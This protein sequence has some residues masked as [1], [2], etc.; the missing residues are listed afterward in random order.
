MGLFDAINTATNVIN[1]KT[2]Q[3]KNI[4][5]GY[6]ISTA[7][8]ASFYSNTISSNLA[9]YEGRLLVAG[10]LALSLP[11]D[12]TVGV[13]V[14]GGLGI[15]AG[16]TALQY[17]LNNI[18]LSQSFAE[19]DVLNTIQNLSAAEGTLLL[20]YTKDALGNIK[21][22]LYSQTDNLQD[23]LSDCGKL[24]LLMKKLNELGVPLPINSMDNITLGNSLLD[25]LNNYDNNFYYELLNQASK[26]FDKAINSWG[27]VH[28]PI[29]LDLNGDGIKTT[30]IANGTY[31]DYAND[32]FAESTAWV[33]VN[34]LLGS[35]ELI[36]EML[37]I[38]S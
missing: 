9:E 6:D 18:G 34:S 7:T 28:D 13:V 32:G 8:S 38:P 5:N 4:T 15:Y 2:T 27:T 22:E 11:A 19:T 1:T 20:A 16:A 21:S 10:V 30:T 14:L 31:F 37:P 29:I 35:W 26:Y 25:L 12:V 17:Y 33:E 24:D 3:D 23:L 36:L